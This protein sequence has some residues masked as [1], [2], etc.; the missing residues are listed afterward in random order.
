[1]QLENNIQTPIAIPANADL[2]IHLETSSAGLPEVEF[3]HLWPEYFNEIKL[4]TSKQLSK[5]IH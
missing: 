2:V 4:Y 3:T 1:M 5:W